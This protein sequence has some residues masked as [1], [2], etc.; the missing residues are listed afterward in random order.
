MYKRN[1]QNWMKH[2]DFIVLDVLCQQVAL[3]ICFCIYNWNHG[4]LLFPYSIPSYH[5]IGIL[6]ALL[7]VLVAILFNTMHNVIKRGYYQEAVQ[8]LKQCLLVFGFLMSILFAMKVSIVYSRIIL[9][10]TTIIHFLLGYLVR[11]AWKRKLKDSIGIKK[12]NKML[13]VASDQHALELSEKEMFWQESNFV[14]IIL[15]NRDGINEQIA[16][17]PVVANMADAANYICREWVDEVF[18]YPDSLDEIGI[19]HPTVSNSGDHSV[20]TLFSQCIEMALP[21]HVRLPMS[22]I[23]GKPFLEKVNGCDVLTTTANYA[24]PLQLFIKRMMDY[25]GGIIGSV[26][27]VLIIVV[28]GPFIK[29]KSPG[30]ILFRQERIG[31]NGKH[32]MM[33]KIRSMD[34]DAEEKK[35]DFLKNNRVADGMMFKL[36]FDPRI[37]G[38]EVL[39]DGTVKTGIGDF[40]RR[41]SLDEFP[42]FFNVLKGDMSLV[43]T[44]PP[45]VDEWEKY[46]FHHRA[47]LSVRPG[48][49]GMWQVSGRSKIVDFEK[50]VELDT[51]YLYNWNLGLDIKILLKTI[52]LVI[53]RKGAL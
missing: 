31:L 41:T 53:L 52:L 8:T 20:S 32:F 48:I 7:D 22:E 4:R 45:T 50:V 51:E 1:P 25:L 17:V 3:I 44:R 49:T 43:G 21:V 26:I 15:T 40:I 37:I 42:Q 12:T 39:P 46:Q 2:W 27:A 29:R 47:R 28:I 34:M 23:G 11:L 6:L 24:S 30:P 33:Y 36:D 10:A 5:T 35:K 16:G 13:L 14:G 18:F 19:H 9:F 38:N